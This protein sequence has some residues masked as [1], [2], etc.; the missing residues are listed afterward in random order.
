MYVARVPTK[1]IMRIDI[2][3]GTRF[4]AY[5]T[6]MGRVLLAGLDRAE[7][8]RYLAE[9]RLDSITHSTVT[10]RDVLRELI[11]EARRSGCAIVDE[12]LEE[13]LRSVAVPIH[14][15]GGAVIAAVNVATHASIASMETMRTT[16]LRAVRETA[17]Y[18]EEDLRAFTPAE[19]KH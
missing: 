13:G 15:V 14:G 10:D 18:I 3:V 11:A 17:K 9:V 1:R 8:E 12:E 5:A 6:S 19:Q 7:L 4:P 2:S 16:L